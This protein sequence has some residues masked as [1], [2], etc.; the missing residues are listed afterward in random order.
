MAKDLMVVN[1]KGAATRLMRLMCEL[2]AHMHHD[3]LHD[4]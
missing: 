3:T 2:P 4:A 1:S